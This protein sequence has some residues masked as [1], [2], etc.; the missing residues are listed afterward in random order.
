MNVDQAYLQYQS[1]L[2][3]SVLNALRARNSYPIQKELFIALVPLWTLIYTF[4]DEGISVNPTKELLLSHLSSVGDIEKFVQVASDHKVERNFGSELKLATKAVAFTSYFNELVSDSLL[5]TNSFHLYDYRGSVIALRCMLEDLYRHLYYK[6]NREHFMQVH[7]LGMPEHDIGMAP[8]G[9]RD[10]LKRASYLRDVLALKDANWS[11][12][13]GGKSFSGLGSLNDALY[14]RYSSFVHGAAPRTLN[15]FASNLD[16]AYDAARGA[17]V[18]DLT[19]HFVLLAVSFLI[20]GHHEYFSR[21]NEHTKR[22]V[23]G[24]FVIPAQR[25]KIRELARI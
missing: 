1:E 19:K 8:K 2:R 17:E 10:Y 23:M 14:A 16:F 25:Q 11:F 18:L 21:F 24:A 13:V 20:F 4:L 22:V 15:Q 6:D 5:L 9:F 3:H 7:E 12:N